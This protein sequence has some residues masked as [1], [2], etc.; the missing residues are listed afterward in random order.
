MKLRTRPIQKRP[1]LKHVLARSPA[2]DEEDLMMAEATEALAE[3]EEIAGMCLCL[4][5]WLW[6]CLSVP[7][8]V[9]VFVCIHK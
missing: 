1:K 2:L 5:L 8:S 9:S 4:W 6:L 7:V 3:D